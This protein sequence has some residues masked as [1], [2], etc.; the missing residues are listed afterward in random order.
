VDVR[1]AW[2]KVATRVL[3]LHGGY[4]VDPQVNRAAHEAV[5][6]FVNR[7]RPGS[8]EFRELPGLDHCWTRHPSLEASAGRCGLGEPAPDLADAILAF[9]GSPK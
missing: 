7:T 8:A 9:L 3:V 2:E 1:S 5:A 4:D 6:A